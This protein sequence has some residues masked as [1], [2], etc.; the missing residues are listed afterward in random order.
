MSV[1]DASK[2][3]PGGIVRIEAVHT[4]SVRE[5]QSAR[6]ATAQLFGGLPSVLLLCMGAPVMLRTNL[7]TEAGL[8][9]GSLGTVVAVVYESPTAEQPPQGLPAFVVVNFPL[10]TGPPFSSRPGEEK[11][12]PVP[13]VSVAKHK[14]N[15]SS[16][17]KQVIFRKQIPLTLAYAITIHKSQGM[18]LDM[19]VVDLGNR[20]LSPGLTFV[21]ISRVKR[22]E[23]L[24]FVSGTCTSERLSS[25]CSP[26]VFSRIAADALLYVMSDRSNDL[27]QKRLAEAI[28]NAKSNPS[29]IPLVLET[30]VSPS[31]ERYR[32]T[33]R[34]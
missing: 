15:T 25:F 6:Q 21:A 16:T 34:E 4:G 1:L 29:R 7:A 26:S 27:F 11:F 31:N 2:E 22:L 24:A 5:I 10:Y 23:G 3:A 14:T 30:T 20:E 28:R 17:G 13:Y 12:V 33:C 9:N 8:V 32:Q 19:A 18:T